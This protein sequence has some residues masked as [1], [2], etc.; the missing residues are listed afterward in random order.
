MIPHLRK[1]KWSSYH[2]YAY[3]KSDPLV[4]PFRTYR[5][6]GLKERIRR[7]QFRQFVETMTD[8]EEYEWKQRLNHP[9]LKTKKDVMKNYL[10]KSGEG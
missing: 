9:Y 8:R 6:F 5:N 1:A 10:Q 4:T 2:F 7:L 3:G